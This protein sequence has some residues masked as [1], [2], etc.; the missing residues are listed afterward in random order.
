MLGGRAFAGVEK[1]VMG[2][3][4]MPPKREVKNKIHVEACLFPKAFL[5]INMTYL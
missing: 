3:K 1:I 2:T 4:K 5:V